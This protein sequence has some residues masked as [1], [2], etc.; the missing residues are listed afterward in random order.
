MTKSN[1]LDVTVEGATPSISITASTTSLPSSGGTVDFTGSTNLPAGSTVY[2]VING[3]SGEYD[4]GSTTVSSSG[5]FSFSET[6][7]ANTYSVPETYSVY[8][9][10]GSVTSNTLTITVAAISES[11]NLTSQSATTLP[12][13]GGTVSFTGTTNL[14]AGTTLDIYVNAGNVG[15]TSVGS[16]GSI[17]FSVAIPSNPTGSTVTYDVYVE[18]PTTGTQ[19]NT[20]A[21]SVAPASQSITLTGQSA[22]TLPSSGGS[23]TFSGT[24]TGYNPGQTFY[25]FVNGV[26]TTTTTLGQHYTF[27]FTLS[28]PANTSTSLVTYD[29]DV[30]DNTSNT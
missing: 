1:V 11:I 18:N 13:S 16:G 12:S 28:F 4:S 30:S 14:P 5:T 8:A 23:V 24:A 7:P 25:V 10:I 29:I 27:S 22:T 17:S 26:N 9:Q 20:A 19:S 15:T 21:I 3:P 2:W 6:F